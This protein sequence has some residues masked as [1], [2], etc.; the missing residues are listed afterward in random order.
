[1]TSLPR[2]VWAARGFH[3]G[4]L[5]VGGDRRTSSRKGERYVEDFARCN[6]LR[7]TPLFFMRRRLNGKDGKKYGERNKEYRDG[8]TAGRSDTRPRF[9]NDD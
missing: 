1:M 7:D 5:N 6:R 2:N 3:P 4:F 8:S 9:K